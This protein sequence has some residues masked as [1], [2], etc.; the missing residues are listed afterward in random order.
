MALR[1]WW[2]VT[3]AGAAC[4]ALLGFGAVGGC[5]A[6]STATTSGGAGAGNG[7]EGG[8]SSGAGNN[9]GSS[10]TTSTGTGMGGTG[11]TGGMGTGS[12][13]SSGSGAG[14]CDGQVVTLDQVNNPNA[15][16][17]VGK[18]TPVKLQGVVA[19]ST[20]FLV[21]Q[22]NSGTCLWG[23]FVSSPGLSETKPYSGAMV[24]SK[25]IPA[26]I[27][28]GGSKAYCPKLSNYKMGDKLPGDAIPDDVKPGDVLD[29]TGVADEYLP[30]TCGQLPTD[31]KIPQ[32]QISFVCAATK[33]GTA[34]VPAPHV[35][36]DPAD[37]AKLADPTATDF[38]QQ[39]GN[40]KVG[41][42]NV[43]PT[44]VMNPNVDSGLV[45]VGQYGDVQLENGPAV[46]DKIYYRG[47]ETNGC[48]K[49]PAFTD[50]MVSW[51]QVVGLHYLNFC[52][53][54]LQAHNKC[55][56]FVAPSEDCGSLM[57]TF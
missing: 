12:S 23:V 41:A 49:G 21:S 51:T 9:T 19:T 54:G 20:K 4:V 26:E 38:H 5:R 40:V 30:S 16:N 7:G 44:L 43:K 10:S 35:F 25:G 8:E 53:W 18:G 52:T 2:F 45:V 34:P 27:P 31:T 32:K 42:A 13:S 17:A 46:G 47:Y 37:I 50:T 39:W 28:A 57:C 1:K 56:D 11:G 3:G 15:P 55:T 14:G 29:I 36:T 48:Y 6:E 22:S 33:T 24:V